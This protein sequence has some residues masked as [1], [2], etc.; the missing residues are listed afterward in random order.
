MRLINKKYRKFWVMGVWVLILGYLVFSFGIVGSDRNSALCS[1]YS[2][3]IDDENDAKYI[4]A[5]EIESMLAKKKIKLTGMSLRDINT[6]MIEKEIGV[7]PSI[8]EVAVYKTIKGDVRIDIKQRQ[9]MLRIINNKNQSFYLDEE[10][11]PMP[12]SSHYSPHLLVA[13]GNIPKVDYSK[14]N[15]GVELPKIL[16]D[17]YTL[18]KFINDDDYWRSQ[19]VQVYVTKK[20]EFELVSRVGDQ[21]IHFGGI[22][23]Y[24]TKFAK[25]DA[26]Y[27]QGFAKYGWFKYEAIDLK[28][29]DQVVC[30]V[31]K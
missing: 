5:S 26:L 8:R 28:F 24:E 31:R 21:K 22:D 14:L 12:H 27:R 17:L 20:K 10:G 25:L 13:G 6:A 9:P 23:D 19:I 2:I 18:A 4:A 3:I 1:G 29:K 15:E 7:H 16:Q 11:Y 30:T